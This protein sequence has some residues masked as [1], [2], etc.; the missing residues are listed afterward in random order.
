M[1]SETFA[2][3]LLEH[4]GVC[5]V[6]GKDFGE[7]DAQRWVRITYATSMAR[8]EEAVRRIGAWLRSR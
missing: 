6:P 8:L 7:H 3:Q 1:S 2:D 4:T 5:I